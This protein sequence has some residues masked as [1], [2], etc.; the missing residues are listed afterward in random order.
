MPRGV[1]KQESMHDADYMPDALLPSIAPH[2]GNGASGASALSPD[3][4]H[5][6]IRN[7][8][9]V[10]RIKRIM[11]ADDDVGKVAQVTPVVVSKALELFMISL[12]TKAAAEAKSRNSKRVGAVHLKQAITKNEQFD[13]LNDIVSKVADAPEK[14]EHD[15]MDVD[16]KKKKAPSRRKKKTDDDDD[17]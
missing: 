9:P 2:V 5:I 8:F 11:Q 15:A 1:P 14:S 3:T 6:N 10:A 13:F 17:F 12:V 16:G 7:H 4:D